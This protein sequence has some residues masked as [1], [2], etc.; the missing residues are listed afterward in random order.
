LFRLI[1]MYL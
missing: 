1:L